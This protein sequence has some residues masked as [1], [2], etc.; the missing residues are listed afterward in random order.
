MAVTK[1]T[2]YGQINISIDVI[3]AMVSNAVYECYGVVGIA[4]KNSIR[5]NLVTILKMDNLSKGIIVTKDGASFYSIDIYLVIAT[6]VKI[7]EV[8]LEVQKKVR[9]V[10]EKTLSLKIKKVNV[11]AQSVMKA[12]E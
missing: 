5:D 6:G 2:K 3:T 8:L 9:Y 12:E 7:T 11:Y 1:N 4:S 10:L